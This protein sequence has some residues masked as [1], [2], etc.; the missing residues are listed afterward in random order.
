MCGPCAVN[1]DCGC[2]ILQDKLCWLQAFQEDLRTSNQCS[3]T[4]ACTPY[5]HNL[6]SSNVLVSLQRQKTASSSHKLRN[7]NTA[8]NQ[9]QYHSKLSKKMTWSR[10]SRRTLCSPL[11]NPNSSSHH[12]VN[13][14]DVQKH[15]SKCSNPPAAFSSQQ[16]LS[17]TAHKHIT[18]S[19]LSTDNP[20][21]E[22]MTTC[23][24][25]LKQSDYM[26]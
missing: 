2:E 7:Q 21:P 18:G 11:L 24:K 1:Y 25:A 9:Q 12:S 26:H 20:L 13:S 16:T 23:I 14:K 22:K 17:Q 4:T 5:R 8:L 3:T 19:G 15:S 10:A 6:K